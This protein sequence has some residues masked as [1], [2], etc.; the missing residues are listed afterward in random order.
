[1]KFAPRPGHINTKEGHAHGVLYVL[2]CLIALAA[3]QQLNQPF[4]TAP[5]THTK[6]IVPAAPGAG[7]PLETYCRDERTTVIRT[8]APDGPAVHYSLR[9]G[10]TESI[11]VNSGAPTALRTFIGPNGQPDS[12]VVNVD[13][14]AWK[15]IFDR[16]G[17]P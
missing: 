17:R 10:G 12:D 11:E 3:Y 7:Y 13:D 4:G 6:K 9:R 1:M 5:L 8:F 14:A 2:L 16:G 15:C